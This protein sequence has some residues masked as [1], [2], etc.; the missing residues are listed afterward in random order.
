MKRVEKEGTKEKE[1]QALAR[2]KRNHIIYIIFILYARAVQRTNTWYTHTYIYDILASRS[3]LPLR[4]SPFPLRILLLSVLLFPSYFSLL[5]HPRAV[6]ECV[7][8]LEF[9]T[10]T[11]G[12]GVSKKKK[13]R[14]IRIIARARALVYT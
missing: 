11:T 14:K 3:S 5:R 4:R 7:L 9:H 12:P 6:I 13:P 8:L 2:K 10:W 1:T